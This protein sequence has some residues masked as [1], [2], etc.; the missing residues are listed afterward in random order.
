MKIVKVKF[1]SNK[2]GGFYFYS[3]RKSLQCKCMCVYLLS[4]FL[5]SIFIFVHGLTG[6]CVYVCVVASKRI[7]SSEDFFFC[8]VGGSRESVVDFFDFVFDG[9]VISR[10]GKLFD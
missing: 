9:H 3:M 4:S 7:E 6:L 5:D 1:L 10:D 8:C 2:I